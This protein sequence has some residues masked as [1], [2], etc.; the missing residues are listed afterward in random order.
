MPDSVRYI[1]VVEGHAHRR[2]GTVILLAVAFVLVAALLPGGRPARAAVL[3][4]GTVAVTA[5]DETDPVAHPKDAADDTAIWIDPVDPAQSLVIGD[6]KRGGLDV[7]DLTGARLQHVTDSAAFFGNVDLRQGVTIDGRTVDV[8]AVNHRKVRFFTV[9]G[10]ARQVRDITDGTPG[11]TGEGMCLFHSPT[12]GKLYVFVTNVAKHRYT[13]QF[14]VVDPDHDGLLSTVLVRT[15]TIGSD[16]EACVVDDETGQLYLSQED[17]ALWQYGAEPTESATARTRVDGIGSDSHLVSDIEGVTVVERGEGSGYLVV[18]AQ[19]VSTPTNSYFAVYR[20]EAPHEFVGTF[21][22][23]AGADADG[24]SRT[25]GIEIS[26]L[27]L[28]PSYP[29]G[30]FIC[31]DDKNTV[32]GSVGNQNFKFVPLDAILM[33]S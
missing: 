19:N 14:E 26:T 16:H 33:L 29:A 31:Q 22:V 3:P 25:D 6:D 18:S 12:S 11:A 13:R 1:R 28:G 17:V 8:V 4:V 7:Y 2:R 27:N 10:T 23:V 32:P 5:V 21:Q 20:R 15:L 24:C 9:D 30:L